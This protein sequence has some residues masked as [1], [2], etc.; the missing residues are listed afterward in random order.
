[1][2][3]TGGIEGPKRYKPAPEYLRWGH[4]THQHLESSS[5]GNL[6]AGNRGLSACY[7]SSKGTSYFSWKRQI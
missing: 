1:M 2:K 6:D 3:D 7:S 4:A 5:T